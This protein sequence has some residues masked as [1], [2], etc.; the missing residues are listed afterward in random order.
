MVVKVIVGRSGY[1]EGSSVGD[2]FWREVVDLWG[3]E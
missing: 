1:A 2:R 3:L